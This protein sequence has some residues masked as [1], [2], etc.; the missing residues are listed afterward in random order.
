M[1][2]GVVEVDEGDEWWRGS[3]ALERKTC[4]GDG[5]MDG[6]AGNFTAA[7]PRR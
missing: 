1:V 2:C 4:A 6:K 3:R 7:L 5:A